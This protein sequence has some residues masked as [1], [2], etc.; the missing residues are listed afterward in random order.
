MIG[1]GGIGVSAL[2]RLLHARGAIV[3]GSDA[4]DSPVADGLR[5]E[6]IT[7]AI[8]HHADQVVATTDLVIH[9]V[10]ISP[11]N[12]ELLEAKRR[13]IPVLTYPQALGEITKEY[14]TIAV[15]GTHGK[16]TT[17]AM[18]GAVLRSV[19]PTIIVGSLLAG[20]GT[21]YIAGTGRT[22]VLEADEYRRAFL[23]Y[24]PKIIVLTNIDIDHLDYYKDLADIQSAFRAFAEKL[25]ADGLLITDL[26]SETIAPVVAGLSCRVVDWR[27]FLPQAKE[28]SLN[29]PGAHNV[30]NAA[31][32]LAV[33]EELGVGENDA[34][35]ALEQFRGTWRRI[36]EKGMTKDGT[37][38]YDDYGHNPTEIA[39]TL[40]A[41]REK[42]PDRFITVLF[43]PH[44][45]S[46]T[47]LQLDGFAHCF[48]DANRVLVTDI[49][50]ARELPDP[51]I[52][53][54]IL[55]QAIGTSHP[56]ARYVG[57]LEGVLGQLG[58]LVPEGG[59]FLTQGAGDG[60]KV[61]EAFLAAN[62]AL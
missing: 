9:T 2:A 25:P 58:A 50:A 55:A 47:R 21:N 10:A 16:T 53:G 44:L 6:G 56:D 42:F 36:E 7:V 59:L 27:T 32:A 33:A 12:P 24:T 52:S 18:V 54:Q 5:R 46:R 30:W 39:V 37:L 61:G 60:Y 19:S 41:L 17:T 8:G 15:C 57:P 31:C 45:Y 62:K 28:L 40:R 34:R 43:Q 20:L 48:K 1:M 26:L 35:H 14:E 29:V 49:Y 4:S 3:A 51:S 38:V 23:N 13:G 22:L 11:E